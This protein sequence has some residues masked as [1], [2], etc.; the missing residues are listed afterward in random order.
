MTEHKRKQPEK[1]NSTPL[2]S[3]NRHYPIPPVRQGQETESPDTMAP[4]ELELGEDFRLLD[5]GRPVRLEHW[6]DCEM[7]CFFLTAIYS[8]RDL[9]A[10]QEEDHF[11]YLQR[12]GLLEGRTSE[13]RGVGLNTRTDAAGNGFIVATVLMGEG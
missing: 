7:A 8:D 10:W 1:N 5:D 13:G 9:H 3:W 12:N 4:P 6:Y 2:V 11:A